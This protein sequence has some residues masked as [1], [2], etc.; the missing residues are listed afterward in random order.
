MRTF[1][2]SLRTVTPADGHSLARRLAEIALAERSSARRDMS[3]HLS[4]ASVPSLEALT[5][6]YFTTVA[7]ANA[8]WPR[9]G[10]PSSAALASAV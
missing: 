10:S 7:A 5:A 6:A 3:A 8:G 9:P 4:T 2:D 1:P